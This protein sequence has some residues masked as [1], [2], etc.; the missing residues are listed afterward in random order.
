MSETRTNRPKDN[1]LYQQKLKAWKPV[2]TF[3]DASIFF[4]VSGIIVLVIGIVIF[5]SDQ[6]VK[7][8]SIDYTNCNNLTNLKCIDIT[9]LYNRS[10]SCSV[11]ME[12]KSN[13]QAP[14]YFYYGLN[15]FY[16][17]HRQLI[18]SYD[19]GQLTGKVGTPA[20]SCDPVRLDKENRIY[21][22]CGQM[23]NVMFNDTFELLNS[24]NISIKWE[25]KN[26][27]HDSDKKR[28]GKPPNWINTVKPPNWPLPVNAVNSEA[29]SGYE[30][31][32]VWMRPAA[33]PRFRKLHR[34]LKSD[35]LTTGNYTIV[36]NYNYP[37]KS[38]GGE[39]YFIVSNLSWIGGK[40]AALG[41]LYIVTGILEIFMGFIV[42]ALHCK[43]PIEQ[44]RKNSFHMSSNL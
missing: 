4:F 15:H 17:N 38:F 44:V 32:M 39:K 29:Y 23:A 12:V 19:M 27:A 31:L 35:S 18:K 2:L 24:N 28:Y 25:S 7:E 16:Q 26:I 30:E 10:C 34:I 42:L 21:A 3:K 20:A 6:N 8:Y 13:I 14:V 41:I 36:I 11:S 5:T 37:V 22:P 40:N 43:Y 1:A 33:L 9:N